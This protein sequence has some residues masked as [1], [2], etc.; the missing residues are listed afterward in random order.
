MSRLFQSSSQ[1]DA[2]TTRKFGGTGLGLAISKQL[3][4]LHGRRG[5]AWRAE[6]GKGSTFWFSARLGISSVNRRPLL[7]DLGLRGRR[8]LVVDDNEHAR[9]VIVD[10]LEGM[11]FVASEA[12][13]GRGRRR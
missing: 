8:A 2:S 5:R 3:A 11:T 12:A 4:E 13:S 9:A 7:P 1:A 6:L 10:M